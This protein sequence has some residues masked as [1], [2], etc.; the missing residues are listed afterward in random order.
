MPG[1]QGFPLPITGVETNLAIPFNS[2]PSCRFAR[3]Q[4]VAI[5]KSPLPSTLLPRLV[6]LLSLAPSGFCTLSVSVAVTSPFRSCPLLRYLAAPAGTSAVYPTAHRVPRPTKC[7]RTFTLLGVAALQG[8]LPFLSCSMLPANPPLRFD[9]WWAL[10]SVTVGIYTF[11]LAPEI[12][13]TCVWGIGHLAM[14][15]CR[16]PSWALRPGL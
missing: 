3:L 4:G 5:I 14:S 11:R 9:G 2:L 1:L 16:R 6:P 15:Q 10:L 13:S 8:F 12:P 7:V